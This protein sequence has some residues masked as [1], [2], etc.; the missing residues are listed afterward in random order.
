MAAMRPSAFAAFKV[1]RQFIGAV[2]HHGQVGDLRAPQE[3]AAMYWPRLE[4]LC[5]AFV[6]V[7]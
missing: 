2:L 3:M 5:V 6:L 4:E 1:D 7:P